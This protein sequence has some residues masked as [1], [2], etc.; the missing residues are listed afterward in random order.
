M[1]ADVTVTWD[2]VLRWRIERHFLG[3]ERAKD[4]V[5]VARRLSGIHAQ[6]ASSA[7]AAADLRADVSAEAI[8]RALLE[9]RTLVKTWA[10][11]GT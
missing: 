6:L 5:E 4:V 2:Q 9:D 3:T 1:R 10:A 11:R 7:Q 8:D